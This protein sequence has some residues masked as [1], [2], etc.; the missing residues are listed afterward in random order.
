MLTKDGAAAGNI[1]L[2]EGPDDR[3]AVDNL[4]RR[5]GITAV[6]TRDKALFD[7]VMKVCGS[8]SEVL[9]I[10]G[11]ALKRYPRVA[12]VIDADSDPDRRWQGLQTTFGKAGLKLPE[13]VD[14][15]PIVI[16]GY[17]PGWKAGVWMFP[18]NTN[19]GALEEF[20]IRILPSDGLPSSVWELAQRSTNSARALGAPIT[21]GNLQKCEIHAY[22]SWQEDPGR[23]YGDALAKGYF[24]HSA[25]LATAFVDWFCEFFEIE[26]QKHT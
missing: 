16:E 25:P 5:H 14:Q 2:F 1:V 15:K 22:L 7:D 21:E 13:R 19:A 8:D 26:Q 20:L 6:E 10:A 18:D 12:L 17:Q 23:P 9:K 11:T 24:N 3:A 4:L